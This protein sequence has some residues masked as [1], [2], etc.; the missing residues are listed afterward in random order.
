MPDSI[1]N[2]RMLAYAIIAQA[3][4]DYL[5]CIK[6]ILFTGTSPLEEVDQLRVNYCIG[7]MHRNESFFRSPLFD[8]LADRGTDAEALIELLH[9]RADEEYKKAL[10]T[11][12]DY[13]SAQTD[14]T[15][16]IA[17]MSGIRKKKKKKSRISEEEL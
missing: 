6:Y 15:T 4:T 11:P 14:T 16:Y 17:R 8:V 10:A 7:Q 2:Y 5:E 12:E 9:K 1:E 13:L 3:A